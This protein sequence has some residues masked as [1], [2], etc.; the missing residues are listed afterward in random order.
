MLTSEGLPNPNVLYFRIAHLKGR[1]PLMQ[2]LGG[3]R[4]VSLSI[5]AHEQT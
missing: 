5:S 1:I 3:V 4:I 2:V